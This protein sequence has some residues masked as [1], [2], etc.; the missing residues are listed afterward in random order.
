MRSIVAAS[1]A[2]AALAVAGCGVEVSAAPPSPHPATATATPTTPAPSAPPTSAPPP[3]T[4]PPP[5]TAAVG[6]PPLTP[7]ASTAIGTTLATYFENLNAG[8]LALAFDVLTPADQLRVGGLATFVT[9]NSSSTDANVVFHT[10]TVQPDCRV[11]VEITFTSYQLP[12]LSPNHRDSCD[13]W[14]LNYVMLHNPDGSW[15][16]DIA[17]SAGGGPGYTAC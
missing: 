6:C 8:N 4:V 13:R 5:P 12:A 10:E 16:I 11:A 2:A 3:T 17:L 7:A 15:S 14:D 1:I 9:T